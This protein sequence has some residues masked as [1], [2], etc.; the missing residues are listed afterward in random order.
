MNYVSNVIHP[1]IIISAA[2]PLNTQ[3]F[4]DATFSSVPAAY[5]QC[6]IIMIFDE[7]HEIYLPCYWTLMS[8]KSESCYVKVF[9]TIN[10][11][12]G[13]KLDPANIGKF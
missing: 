8:S 7:V 5:Y 2:S 3:L 12:L 10:D 11:D 6:L 1:L 13:G 9:Q 4:F